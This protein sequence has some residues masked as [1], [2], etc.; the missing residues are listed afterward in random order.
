MENVIFLLV[1]DIILAA[2]SA[3]YID[4]ELEGLCLLSGE[5]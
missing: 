3:A 5:G 1:G 2:P 4:R